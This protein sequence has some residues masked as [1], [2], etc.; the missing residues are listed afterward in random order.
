M[1]QFSPGHD[2]DSFKN[3]FIRTFLYKTAS[4]IF[5]FFLLTTFFLNFHVLR[6]FRNLVLAENF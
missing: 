1:L 5:F 6:D 3:S 2:V 4:V